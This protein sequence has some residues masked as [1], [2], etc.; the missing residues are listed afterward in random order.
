[1]KKFLTALAV[2]VLTVVAAL[3][4]S[5]CGGKDE[6]KYTVTEEEWNAAFD[7]L[8][9]KTDVDRPDFSSTIVVT[10]EEGGSA[11]AIFD[12][13]G[14]KFYITEGSGDNKFE[15]R[16]WKGSDGVTYG[17]DGE[18]KAIFGDGLEG[19]MISNLEMFFSDIMDFAGFDVECKYS[20]F[21]FN[22]DNNVYVQTKDGNTICV[23]FENAKI[24]AINA[25][26]VTEGVK[27][28]AECT[29]K[30]NQHVTIPEEIFNME[31]T[32]D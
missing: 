13:S 11:N 25:E 6:V 30:Y 27:T 19:I 5:A 23:K 26:S 9:F 31:I 21:T 29:I 28:T 7:V 16:F 4:F 15:Y 12:F 2:G 1:M 8:D 3:G 10:G 17:W 22:A 24:V 18:T 32:K 20:D 14:K